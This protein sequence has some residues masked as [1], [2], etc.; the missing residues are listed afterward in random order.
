[1]A[2]EIGGNKTIGILILRDAQDYCGNFTDNMTVDMACGVTFSTPLIL[3]TVYCLYVACRYHL[4]QTF[5]PLFYTFTC[6]GLSASIGTLILLHN[7][8]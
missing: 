2:F 5:F 3:G 8:F 7:Q 6:V 1:M 4:R